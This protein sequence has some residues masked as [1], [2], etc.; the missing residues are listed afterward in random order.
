MDRGIRIVAE[1]DIPGHTASWC[2]GY[3]TICPNPLCNTSKNDSDKPN[4]ILNPSNNLTYQIITD[5]LSD[6]GFLGK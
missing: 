1:F 5:V 6:I 3:P 4:G 2:F